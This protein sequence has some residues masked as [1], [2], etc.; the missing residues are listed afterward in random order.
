MNAFFELQFGGLTGI[1]NPPEIPLSFSYTIQAIPQIQLMLFDLTGSVESNLFKSN[2]ASNGAYTGKF[3]FGWQVPNANYGLTNFQMGHYEKQTLESGSDNLTVFGSNT[4][5]PMA[6]QNQIN[7][8]A[9][10]CL[11]KFADIHGYDLQ[12]TPAFGS[13]YMRDS[14][15]Q[16]R[17]TTE[18]QELKY[19]KQQNESDM[20]F[21]QR[22]IQY[23]RDAN[24][25]SGYIAVPGDGKGGTKPVLQI[26]IPQ[27]T[28]VATY[29]VQSKDSQVIL[30]G[31][32]PAISV[33]S[34]V[35]GAHDVHINTIQPISGDN[36]KL[37]IN[38]PLMQQNGLI[39]MYRQ[40]DRSLYEA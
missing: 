16:S 23:G 4:L 28:I 17:N 35:L 25:N 12:I 5:S 3:D 11:Q 9:K 6:S 8:T 32:K 18:L 22:I 40:R 27:Q 31:W 24:G 39:R 2:K 1:Y 29:D 19:T 14:G 38:Q 37:N 15:K 30:G 34:S 26:I 13:H 21:V 33:E 20:S 10:E 7:G 36:C